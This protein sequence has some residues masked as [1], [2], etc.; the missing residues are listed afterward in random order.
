MATYVV[1]VRDNDQQIIEA[2]NF[3][4]TVDGGVPVLRLHKQ[5]HETRGISDVVAI[6]RQW[7]FVTKDVPKNGS[8]V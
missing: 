3:E 2:S 6:F 8:S 4:V 5:V 7:E 1:Q